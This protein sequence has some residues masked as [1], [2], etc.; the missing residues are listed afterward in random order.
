MDKKILKDMRELREEL[1]K[2]FV[3]LKKGEVELREV[4]ELNNTAG[5][6]INTVRAQLE[7]CKLNKEKVNIDYLNCS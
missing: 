6:I 5:K 7:K 2:M 1:S 4:A 3:A